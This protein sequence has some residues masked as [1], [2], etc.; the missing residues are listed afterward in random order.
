MEISGV[1]A[2][3]SGP[4]YAIA[5]NLTEAFG[6]GGQMVPDNSVMGQERLSQSQCRL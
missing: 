6:R 5:L 1:T 3:A 4:D 2:V